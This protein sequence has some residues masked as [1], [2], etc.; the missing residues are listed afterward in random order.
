MTALIEF[1]NNLVLAQQIFLCIAIPATLLLVILIVMMLIGFGNDDV[2]SDTDIA[3][4]FEGD[5]DASATDSDTLDAGLSFFTLRGIVSM[6]CIMGWS[7]L[8]FLDA[9]MG[10]PVWAGVAISVALGILTLFLVALAMRGISRLQSSGNLDLRNAIGKVGQVYLTIPADGTS[11][12]KVNL[13]VQ[14]Q[15]KEFT[16]ITTAKEPIKTGQY[17]RVVSVSEAGVLLVEPINN[18]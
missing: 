6:F 4:E 11:A 13:T 8:I 14:D 12:G 3:D 17:V 7:G 10:L 2:D 16:A 5:G 1:W 18:K 9:E 15:F